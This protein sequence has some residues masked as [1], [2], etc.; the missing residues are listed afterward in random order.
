MMILKIYPKEQ[1]LVKNYAIKHLILLKF[2]K[3]DA[4]QRVLASVILMFVDKKFITPVSKP[5]TY[6]G[7]IKNNILSNQH[8]L[9]ELHKPITKKRRK[10][11]L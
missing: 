2:P 9:E 1:L 11:K 6:G 7:A 3:Y 8:L 4:Y 5:G 10:Y